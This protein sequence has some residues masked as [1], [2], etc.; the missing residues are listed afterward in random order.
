[1]TRNIYLIGLIGFFAFIAAT[2]PLLAADMSAEQAKTAVEHWVKRV[3]RP[4]GARIGQTVL[5]A[6]T[7]SDDSGN[8]LFHV[9]RFKEGGFAVASA[10]DGVEPV[11]AFSDEDDLVAD[12]RNPLWVMLNRDLPQR[13]TIAKQQA[14]LRHLQMLP[15][16]DA[17]GAQWQSLFSSGG[18]NTTLGVSS[19]SDVRVSPF[20]TTTW[21]QQ[22]A[23][24]G[25]CYNYYTPPY[26]AGTS[27]NYPCGCVATAGSQLMRYHQYPAT[28]V[29][30]GTYTIWVDSV[31]SNAAMMGGAYAWSDMVVNP[32][33][34]STTLAQRQAIGKLTYDVG[35]ACYMSYA[36]GGSGAYDCNLV[37]ALKTRFGYANSIIMMNQSSGVSSYLANAALSNLDAKYPVIFGISGS[38][39][40][41]EI[42]GD[43]YGYSSGTLYVHLNLGWGGDQ[44]AWYN[45][46]TIDTAY[47]TFTLLGSIVFNVFPTSTVEVVSG[48]VLDSSGS[49][50]S[51]A[52]VV[53]TNQSSSAGISAVTSD[54]NGIYALLVPEPPSSGPQRTPTYQITASLGNRRATASTTVKASKS[55]TYSYTPSTGGSSYSPG[56]GAVGNSWGNNLTLSDPVPSAP[57]GVTAS[58]GAS[59]ASVTVSWS[60]MVYATGY[61]VYRYT[62]DTSA[63][64]SLLGSVSGTNYTDAM[65]TPGTLYYYWVK[66]T[67]STGSS[68]LSASDSG[69]RALAAPAGVSAT[70]SSTGAV[71]VAWGA[72]TGA[73]YYRVYRATTSAGT[74]TA[75]GTWQAGLTYADTSAAAGITYYYWVA[76]AVDGSGT[77]ASAYS[78]YD[79]GLRFASVALDV[80]L[81]TTNLVWSTGGG[82][83]FGQTNV[84]YDGVD[85]ARSG[86]LSDGQTN[87][88]RT[89]IIGPG[90]LSFWWNVSSEAGADG[91]VFGADGTNR[92][93]ISG[94]TNWSQQTIALGVGSHTL[95]WTYS[96]NGSSSSGLDCGWVDRVVWTATGTTTTEVS[97]PYAWL[98]AYGLATG[99]D[100]EAAA[101]ADVDGDG[102]TAWQ[103]YV[104]G[105]S[106][107][108]ADSVFMATIAMSNG[109]PLVTWTPDLG[110]ARVY[111]VEGKSVLTNAAWAS[112]TNSATHFF[113]V[114]V[115][116][117]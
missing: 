102:L 34:S 71:T 53:A 59:T 74:K 54:A 43:G 67:N 107:T 83:W 12:A 42:V 56:T 6:K 75:L 28:S 96:K 9:V 116:L 33:A 13:R 73:S 91:L 45:L 19:V 68:A 117:P 51:G 37:D 31:S 89:T 5:S 1:M 69:Y 24:G 106:P 87:W 2:L 8:A 97:V 79:T 23:Y 27:A 11:I 101:K 10:D 105:T 65:A 52:T 44:N 100:Y 76:A 113:R 77:R 22:T 112:P 92:W 32:A 88:L 60:A 35:V 66:A 16:A 93:T 64:A 85:A 14:A 84:A 17:H 41:H 58:D 95:T 78:D 20:L 90:V 109:L 70:E 47:Y 29:T 81:D 38:G 82:G 108:N 48:R 55:T 72:V 61:G 111:T 21:S 40:G 99:G 18:G 86:A 104:A 26:S 3:S 36:S 63:S 80:A 25:A 49:P 4:L 30:P 98:N 46:P 94:L 15:D 114:K 110:T 7:F 62:A 103:E 39:E 57:A 50:V 115:L